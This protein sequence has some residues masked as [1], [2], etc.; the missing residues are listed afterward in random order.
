MAFKPKHGNANVEDDPSKTGIVEAIIAGGIRVI[1]T[2]CNYVWYP[3][4][5]AL[6][7][8]D[9]KIVADAMT[10]AYDRPPVTVRPVAQVAVRPVKLPDISPSVPE[11]V[12]ESAALVAYRL[13]VPVFFDGL[14]DC[15]HPEVMHDLEA[16]FGGPQSIAPMDY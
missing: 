16:V 6:K 10:S 7:R 2:W 8:L 9:K 12:K 14:P 11:S 1:Y 13:G 4:V 15:L 5:D 3:C